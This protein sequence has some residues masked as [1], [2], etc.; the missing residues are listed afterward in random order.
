MPDATP[1]P[2]APQLVERY[3]RLMEA[4]DFAAAEKMLAPGFFMVF[5]PDR[6]FEKLAD[7]AAWARPRYQWVKKRFERFDECAGPGGATIVYSF[8]RLY[9]VWPDGAAFDNIRYIDRFT[10]K[11]GLLVDQMVWNDM[12]ETLLAARR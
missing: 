9:G 2:T 11:G 1:P 6:R 3:L 8:G 10:V 7:V 12:G 4:R 5:P